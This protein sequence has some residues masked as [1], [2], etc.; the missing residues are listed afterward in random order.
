MP[1]RSFQDLKVWKKAHQWV[2]AVYEFTSRFPKHEIFGLVSQFR[3]AAVSVPAN[4]AEGFRK[5]CKPDKIRFYNIAQ[6]SLS[7]CQ[8]YLILAGDLG[9]GAT[10]VL[11]D[12]STEID[13]MLSAYMR[14]IKK[15]DE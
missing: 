15:V 11:F 1:S 2:L 12:Q 3:R 10:D 9:Y 4:I 6:G 7:E 8:Y 14:E 5:Q 13:L